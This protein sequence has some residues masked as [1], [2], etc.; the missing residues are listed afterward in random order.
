MRFLDFYGFAQGAIVDG[1]DFHVAG[2]GYRLG[3]DCAFDYF[4][5]GPIVRLIIGEHG[6]TY[7]FARF[8]KFFAIGFVKE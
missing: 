1:R 8:Y 6:Q 3:V 2:N 5:C 4:P 7:G